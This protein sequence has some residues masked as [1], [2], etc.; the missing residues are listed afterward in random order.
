MGTGCL[1]EMVPCAFKSCWFGVV[2][3]LAGLG[4]W[5]SFLNDLSLLE[6][7]MVGSGAEQKHHRVQNHSFLNCSLFRFPGFVLLPF[8]ER[9]VEF[10]TPKTIYTSSLYLQTASASTL[11]L[12]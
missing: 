2:Q 5:H 7:S 1:I 4:P 12:T 10:E 6:L 8:L 11:S 9:E 3:Q